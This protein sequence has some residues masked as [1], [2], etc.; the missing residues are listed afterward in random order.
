[1]EWAGK[2]QI[3]A[4]EIIKRQRDRD[5][6]PDQ[7]TIADEIARE[8]RAD[9]IVGV[10]GK[11]LSGATIKRHTLKGISSAQGKQQSTPKRRGK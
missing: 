1:V 9:G 3:R 2:A 11:P 7:M 8:F 5:L 6:Y 4:R 10:D